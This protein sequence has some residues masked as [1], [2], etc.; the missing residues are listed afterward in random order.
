[1]A[2]QYIDAEVRLS[3]I[4]CSKEEDHFELSVEDTLSGVGFLTIKLTPSQLGLMIAGSTQ[5]VKA[6][7]RGTHVIGMKYVGET[8]AIEVADVGYGR[9]LYENW[10]K[11]NYKEDGWNV[12]T[13]LGSQG[14]ISVS[15]NG[16]RT[17][18]FRVYKYVPVE[19]QCQD[20]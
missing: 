8:R 1:M 3:R 19:A 17:L 6:T 20:Q 15:K 13:Y 12:S 4:M 7:I 5:K 9:E 2:T 18:K 10:L 14:S 11:E 16:V